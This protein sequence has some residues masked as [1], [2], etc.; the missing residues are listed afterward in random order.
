MSNSRWIDVKER[1]PEIGQKIL[2]YTSFNSPGNKIII[3]GTYSEWGLLAPGYGCD[4]THW[5]P[6][7]EPPG[8]EPTDKSSMEMEGYI[9][10]ADMPQKY[11]LS[12]DEQTVIKEYLDKLM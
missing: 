4:F 11:P 5:M 3:A 8:S 10:T 6:Q 2:G 9:K 7:P 12:E 1:M